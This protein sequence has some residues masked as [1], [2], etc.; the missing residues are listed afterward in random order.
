MCPVDC[1]PEVML[2]IQVKRD[3]RFESTYRRLDVRSSRSEN[4]TVLIP[5]SREDRK[6]LGMSF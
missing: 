1:D 4:L 3:G 6:R 5:D 2:P